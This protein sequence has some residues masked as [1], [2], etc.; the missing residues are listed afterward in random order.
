M[1]SGMV[2]KF[3]NT[4]IITGH[5]IPPFIHARNAKRLSSQAAR[6]W[7]PHLLS[8]SAPPFQPRLWQWFL[9]SAGLGIPLLRYKSY[10]PVLKIHIQNFTHNFREYSE[11]KQDK[12]SFPKICFITLFFNAKFL[13]ALIPYPWNPYSGSQ[14]PL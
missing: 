6:L 10:L 3:C 12:V 2:K 1:Y 8:K 9:T 5:L 14:G 13:I 7:P 11:K 4:T